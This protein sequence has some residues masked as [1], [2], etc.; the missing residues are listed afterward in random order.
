MRG[1]STIV[2][3]DFTMLISLPT[4]CEQSIFPGRIHSDEGCVVNVTNVPSS[5]PA[6]LLALFSLTTQLQ[7]NSQSQL[8]STIFTSLLSHFVFLISR[9]IVSRSPT[10]LVATSSWEIP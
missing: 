3:N 10:P 2:M 8:S 6:L 5:L 9:L 7:S 4:D 1:V